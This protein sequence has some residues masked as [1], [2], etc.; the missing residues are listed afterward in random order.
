MYTFLHINVEYCNTYACPL[1]TD[2]LLLNYWYEFF[3]MKTWVLL[4]QKWSN[5]NMML[6]FVRQIKMANKLSSNI[7]SRRLR[8]S[9]HTYYKLIKSLPIVIL[10]PIIL[11]HMRAWKIELANISCHEHVYCHRKFI[12]FFIISLNNTVLTSYMGSLFP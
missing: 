7:T 10:M 12:S 9:L 5:H 3:G 1:W 6:L 11:H 2:L 4:I 8:T